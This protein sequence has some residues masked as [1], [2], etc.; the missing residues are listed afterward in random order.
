MLVR[1]LQNTKARPFRKYLDCLNSKWF[2][3]ACRSQ[4]S[5]SWCRKWLP[6][7]GAKSLNLVQL[8]SVMC[9]TTDISSQSIALRPSGSVIVATARNVPSLVLISWELPSFP[10]N[11]YSIRS[12]QNGNSQKHLPQ[13]APNKERYLLVEKKPPEKDFPTDCD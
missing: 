7:L 13:M 10:G 4:S 8:E 5:A 3:I 9:E 12:Q 11:L 2:G 6:P 1:K